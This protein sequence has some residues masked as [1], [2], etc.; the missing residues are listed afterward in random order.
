M[1]VETALEKVGA[2]ASKSGIWKRRVRALRQRHTRS[3]ISCRMCWIRKSVKR[4]Q[5]SWRN[6][7]R[8]RLIFGRKWWCRLN[9]H[10]FTLSRAGD[11]TMTFGINSDAYGSNQEAEVAA[12][13]METIEQSVP[14]K[15]SQGM[16]VFDLPNDR[17]GTRS[18]EWDAVERSVPELMPGSILLDARPPASWAAECCLAVDVKNGGKLHVWTLYKNEYGVGMWVEGMG[19]GASAEFWRR[20]VVM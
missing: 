16:R 15:E 11:A 3:L 14:S 19:N 8:A 1:D 17:S 2:A 20:R 7:P 4:F 12:L 9:L 10:R 6:C 18:L 13:K 5:P